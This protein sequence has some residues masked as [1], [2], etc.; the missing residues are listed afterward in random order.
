[1]TL[2][3]R[4]LRNFSVL[5]QGSSDQ[6]LELYGQVFLALIVHQYWRN[7]WT[8]YV[9]TC[10]TRGIFAQLFASVSVIWQN[11]NC[12][13]IKIHNCIKARS[14]L[15][16]GVFL[17]IDAAS[18]NDETLSTSTYG[19]RCPIIGSPPNRKVSPS[20]QFTGKNPPCPAA[21]RA[22]RIFIN[23]LSAGGD[24]PVRAIL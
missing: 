12:R 8:T 7:R 15:T 22:G 11:K 3:M 4:R 13:P 24:F 9:V 6:K 10:L 19:C 5:K 20:R 16:A 2:H 17:I 23:K 1:M 14:S 18:C 21:V